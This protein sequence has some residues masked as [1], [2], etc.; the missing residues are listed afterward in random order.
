MS[1]GNGEI[2]EEWDGLYDTIVVA[3]GLSVN[4]LLRLRMLRAS[5]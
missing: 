5:T 3:A 2:R 4:A 1:K